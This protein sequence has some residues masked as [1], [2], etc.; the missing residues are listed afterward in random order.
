MLIKKHQ[1][2][3][4]ICDGECVGAVIRDIAKKPV[5]EH[6]GLKMMLTTDA[7]YPIKRGSKTHADS[8]TIVAHGFHAEFLDP[9][10]LTTYAYTKKL[11]LE[12]QKIYDEDGDNFRKFLYLNAY[13]YL[14]WIIDSY[15]NFKK[16]VDLEDDKLIGAVF[17]AKNYVAAG[18]HDNDRSEWA[19]GFCYD[20]PNLINKGYFIYS[21]YEI[22]IKMTSNTLWYWKTQYVHGTTTLDLG[23]NTRYTG[24]ITLTEKIAKAIEAKFKKQK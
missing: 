21:K 8:G 16:K 20:H 4:L 3:C 5:V 22:A 2:V 10:K 24:A 19:V 6:F 18:Y 15:E 7:Y 11:S 9:K 12:E 23:N 13:N 17:C 1:S 14:C